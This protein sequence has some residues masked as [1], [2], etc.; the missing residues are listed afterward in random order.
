M[1]ESNRNAKLEDLLHAINHDLR[2]PLS[3]IRS[4]ASILKNDPNHPLTEEQ[5]VFIDIIERS[6]R[7]ILDQSNRLTLFNQIAFDQTE[8][9]QVQLS[10]LLAN[11]KQML[12]NNYQIEEITFNIEDDP[13]IDCHEH[14]L[15]AL[16]ALLAAGDTKQDAEAMEQITPSIQVTAN[17][18]HILFLILSRMPG[19]DLLA[20]S[21][22]ELS[23]EI[24]RLHNGSLT[25]SDENGRIQ[26]ILSLPN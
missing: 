13:L 8:P 9:V 16:I 2:T 21:Y 6:T 22:Q 5:S 4:V 19:Q 23:N 1:A 24:V 10:E 11:A 17:G 15:A 12:H 20:H 14:V 18:N 26:F 7:R 3:N 25:Y